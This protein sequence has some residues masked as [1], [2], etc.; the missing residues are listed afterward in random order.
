LAASA[1]VIY[2]IMAVRT[3]EQRLRSLEDSVRA[4]HAMWQSEDH[5]LIIV[6]EH[7]VIRTWNPAL[8]R[9]TGRT[10]YEMIGKNLNTIM[11]DDGSAQYLA[12]SAEAMQEAHGN[13]ATKRIEN[14]QLVPK[15]EAAEPV[16]VTMSIRGFRTPDSSEK[17]YLVVQIDRPEVIVELEEIE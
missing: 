15:D 12:K 3:R 16:D 9:W 1:A 4:M 13:G 8:E 5:G 2:L 6:D 11:S 14:L 7:A 17:P 10:A